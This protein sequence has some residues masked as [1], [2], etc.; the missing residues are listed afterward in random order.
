MSATEFERLEK[1]RGKLE[2]QIHEKQTE[3][4]ELKKKYAAVEQ[5]IDLLYRDEAEKPQTAKVVEIKRDRYK[6]MSIGEA[7]SDCINNGPLRS[8]SRPEIVKFL[9]DNG[10]KS[11]SKNLYA[12]VAGTL[13]H[14][15]KTKRVAIVSTPQGKR[16]KKI[17]QASM[18][19]EAEGNKQVATP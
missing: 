14:L 5:V 6:E 17:Q 13:Q 4:A 19:E 9:K 2:T 18:T 3:I 8:W 11:K 10:F 7:I 12:L 16:F 15:E 1:I